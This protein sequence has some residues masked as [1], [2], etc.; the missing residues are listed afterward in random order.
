MVCIISVE[1]VLVIDHHFRL[2]DRLLV[3]GFVMN[4]LSRTEHFIAT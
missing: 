1:L 2:G 3:S 4:D